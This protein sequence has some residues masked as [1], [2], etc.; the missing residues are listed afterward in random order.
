MCKLLFSKYL[1]IIN[2]DFNVIYIFIGNACKSMK[3]I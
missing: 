3:E 2:K 1:K